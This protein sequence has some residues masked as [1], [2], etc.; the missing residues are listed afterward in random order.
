MFVILMGVDAIVPISSLNGF[1]MVNIFIG[2]IGFS[3][4]SIML[5][6]QR[7][8]KLKETKV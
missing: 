8:F 4:V 2:Y 7:Y 5:S 1:L 6:I 3:A